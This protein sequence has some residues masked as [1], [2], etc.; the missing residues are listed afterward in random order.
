MLGEVQFLAYFQALAYSIIKNEEKVAVKGKDMQG[1][2]LPSAVCRLTAAGGSQLLLLLNDKRD[3]LLVDERD[4]RAKVWCN[5]VSI[6]PT[7]L[8]LPYLIP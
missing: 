6:L 1:P 3:A 7:Y 2:H 4:F 5:V 8:T